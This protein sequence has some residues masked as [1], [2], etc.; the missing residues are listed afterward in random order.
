MPRQRGCRGQRPPRPW[1]LI[2]K[3]SLLST[4]VE[5]P[6]S[7]SRGPYGVGAHRA[8]TTPEYTRATA[9]QSHMASGLKSWISARVEPDGTAPGPWGTGRAGAGLPGLL[10]PSKTQPEALVW[11]PDA[12]EKRFILASSQLFH[13][14]SADRWMPPVR[15]QA[16]ESS[17]DG[18]A[19]LAKADGGRREMGSRRP[20][21]TV[22]HERS[23]LLDWG[24]QAPVGAAVDTRLGPPHSQSALLVLWG[25]H[26]P[27]LTMTW[28]KPK[29]GIRL[30][31]W[32]L[33]AECLWAS[34][35]LVSLDLKYTMSFSNT[36]YPAAFCS[37]KKK[38]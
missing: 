37:K 6:S 23:Q 22:R 24:Q 9:G 29:Q 32:H 27:W 10:L 33:A 18:S 4:V 20:K 12:K 3:F 34:S 7:L 31:S 30:W 2:K 36:T 17:R 28:P 35:S 26:A 16:T 25:L 8:S 19:V 13:T 5:Q 1:H 11:A 21:P 15:S 14:L 38:K